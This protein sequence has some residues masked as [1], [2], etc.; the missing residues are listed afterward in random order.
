MMEMTIMWRTSIGTIIG[1]SLLLL[2]AACESDI[3]VRADSDSTATVRDDSSDSADRL[4]TIHRDTVHR[5]DTIHRT[6]TVVDVDTVPPPPP[7][8][9]NIRVTAPRAHAEVG[10]S[11][12]LRGTA[13]TF[14][15]AVSY[16]VVGDD[17][18]KIGEGYMTAVGEMGSFSPYSTTVTVTRGYRG[19]ARLEVYQS[20]A[21]DGSEIDKVIVPIIIGR[22]TS[23]TTRIRLFYT[24]AGRGSERD[25][26]KVFAVSRTIPRT[27]A[28]AE[29]ALNELL[30]GPTGAEQGK[31]Y[32]NE[33]PPGTRLRDI[34]IERGVAR[35]D[36]S[37]EL[38]SAAG[39]CR[40]TAIRSQIER[41]LRQF[42]TVTS[43]VI[44]VEGR[45]Q[46]VLQP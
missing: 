18:R 5:T 28:V 13:R 38:N 21:K 46:G 37:S 27:P 29:A 34:T 45:A 19:A 33:I 7:Q 26:A 44:S 23:G 2:F 40:V 25:C 32:G 12:E 11:F 14:E 20:S 36:F 15:N 3:E 16:R 43:V 6:D 42:P 39:A 1:A 22:G 10:E 35:A 31:G 24:N 9:G 17:G 41:T 4:G 30:A 8:Q